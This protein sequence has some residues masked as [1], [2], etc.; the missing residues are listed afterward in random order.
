MKAVKVQ[1][2]IKRMSINEDDSVSFSATTP[3]LTDEEL[4][5]FRTLRKVNVNALLEPERGSSTV[6][7][8]KERVDDGKSPSQRLRSVMFI[9]WEQQGRPGED[10]EQF[11]RMKME[12]VIESVKGKLE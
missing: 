11:Y 7:E 12:R 10:F 9:W 8:I 1:L 2:Q 6:L 3:A 4:G 5:V